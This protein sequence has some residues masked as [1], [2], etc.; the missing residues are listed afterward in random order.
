M[1]RQEALPAC[2]V[3]H[4]QAEEAAAHRL[5]VEGPLDA[6]ALPFRVVAAA[7]AIV[8]GVFVPLLRLRVRVRA[9]RLTGRR[10]HH[11]APATFCS[12]DYR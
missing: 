8:H 12:P 4:S 11:L 5:G 10:R 2:E 7:F 3:F 1:I 9:L 6:V